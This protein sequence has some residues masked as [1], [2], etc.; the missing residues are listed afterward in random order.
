MYVRHVCTE[1]SSNVTR[2]FL[3][4]QLIDY[5]QPSM[6]VM[7]VSMCTV[8][9]TSHCSC[10]RPSSGIRSRRTWGL[11]DMSMLQVL[12][13]TPSSSLGVLLLASDYICSNHLMDP[14]LM[15][16]LT[17][18][19]CFY[20][21]IWFESCW[22]ATCEVFW[23]SLWIA[24]LSALPQDIYGVMRFSINSSYPAG[25][26]AV[27]YGFCLSTICIMRLT[28]QQQPWSIDVSTSYTSLK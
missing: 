14:Q 3:V 1:L 2:S 17:I 22:A 10:L 20:S 23:W 16:N 27:R 26:L 4:S 12:R 8:H 11:F 15:P 13:S 21:N 18:G 6:Y 5:A 25:D 24:S 19:Q 28:N 9:C 7:H